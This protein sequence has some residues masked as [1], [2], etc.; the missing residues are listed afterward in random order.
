MTEGTRIALLEKAR[1]V[2]LGGGLPRSKL[3]LIRI[4]A[5]EKRVVYTSQFRASVFE[6]LS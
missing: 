3:Q 2:K 5:R 4:T 1:R 6:G